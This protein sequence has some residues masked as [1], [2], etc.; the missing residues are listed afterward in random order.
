MYDPDS[1]L[2]SQI[3]VKTKTPLIYPL[4][5]RWMTIGVM[6]FRESVCVIA[7]TRSD[8]GTAYFPRV[9]GV[10]KNPFKIQR[11]KHSNNG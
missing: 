6:E 5:T 7:T 1:K 2:K 8:M 3:S 9:S 4:F 11:R 10:K